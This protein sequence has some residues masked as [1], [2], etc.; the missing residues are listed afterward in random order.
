MGCV[1]RAG[2][3]G[4]DQRF[5]VGQVRRPND[6]PGAEVTA[7]VVSPD[8]DSADDVGTGL[9]GGG[10]PSDCLK[11]TIHAI[12]APVDWPVKA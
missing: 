3:P 2:S 10:G 5:W 6:N 12:E 1:G 7:C 4:V 11:A 9:G 8:E